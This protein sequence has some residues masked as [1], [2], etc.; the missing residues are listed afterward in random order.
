MDDNHWVNGSETMII[1]NDGGLKQYTDKSLVV[2][3]GQMLMNI[4]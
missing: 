3:G 1:Q 4:D 2:G